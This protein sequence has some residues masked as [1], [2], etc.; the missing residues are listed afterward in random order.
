MFPELKAFLD[1]T[2]QEISRPK[3]EHKRKTHCSGKKKR[4]TVKTQLTVN[5]NGLIVHLTHTLREA[6]VI[7]LCLNVVARICSIRFWE[8]VILAIGG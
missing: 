4:H 6:C 5:A 8:R 7:T 2:E 1:A 3:N